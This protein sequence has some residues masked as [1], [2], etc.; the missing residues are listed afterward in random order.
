[1]SLITH[2][3]WYLEKDKTYN[4]ETLPLIDHAENDAENE[5]Q[6]LVPDPHFI[7]VNNLNQP[8]H[9][10]FFLKNKIL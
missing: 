4:I 8:L 1:M 9:A 3:V 5:Y 2:P 6:K 7:L 10:R